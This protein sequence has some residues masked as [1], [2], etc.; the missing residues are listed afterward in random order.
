MLKLITKKVF[1]PCKLR[2]RKGVFLVE[3]SAGTGKTFSISILYLRLL[4]GQC[5]K[6]NLYKNFLE[7]EKILILTFSESD[8]KEFRYRLKKEIR[9]F[10]IACIRGYSS[11]KL[12][13]ELLKQIINIDLVILRLLQ[14]E[15]NM[16][17]SSIFTIYSF[18]WNILK[19][20]PIES[21]ILLK[22][23]LLLDERYLHKKAVVN[24]WRRYFYPLNTNLIKII[25][26]YWKDPNM[27]FID[28]K[29]YLI[30]KLP[31]IC[32]FSNIT[33]SFEERYKLIISFINKFKKQWFK[34]SVNICDIFKYYCFNKMK[35]TEKNFLFWL[36]KIDTWTRTKTI[37]YEIPKELK[38]FRNMI[39]KKNVYIEKI[40]FYKIPFYF[41]FKNL[42]RL[43]HKIFS[44]RELI[45]VLALKEVRNEIKK[46][47][48]IRRQL[49]YND[50]ILKLDC[51]LN[52]KYKKKLVDFIQFHYPVV[53]I[54]GFQDIDLEQYN[55]LYKIYCKN[56]FYGCILFFFSDFKQS[57][58][59]IYT[60]NIFTYMRIRKEICFRYT[61]DINYRSSLNLICAINQ[62]F[63]S[64][65][66][67]FVFKDISFFPLK[68]CVY[69]N[70]F[71]FF[72]N[73]QMQPA[74]H[75]FFKS[76]CAITSDEY[77]KVMS[78]HFSK[79]I[80]D[81][82]ISCIKEE[83]YLTDYFGNRLL[84]LSDIV[85]LVRNSNE[86]KII[87]D[88]LQRFMVPVIFFSNFNNSVFETMEAKDILW[89]L[90]AILTPEDHTIFY[91]A[92]FTDILG[93]STVF[94]RNIRDNKNNKEKLIEK[95]IF[96]RSIWKKRGVSFMLHT[97]L[98]HH[99]MIKNLLSLVD[100]RQRFINVMHIMELLQNVSR[101]FDNQQALIRWLTAQ[102]ANPDSGL[103]N[104]KVR[105]YQYDNN[106]V[107]IMTI[108]KSRGL[109]FPLV[110]LP[111]VAN[112]RLRKYFFF[113]DR[114]TYERKLDFRCVNEKNFCFSDE[115]RLAEDIRLLYVA[116]TRSI[117]YCCIGISPIFHSSLY[118]NYNDVSNV[119][120]SAIGFL[121]QKGKYGDFDFLHKSLMLLEKE[122]NKNIT[123]SYVRLIS[124]K[125]FFGLR[126][127]FLFSVGKKFTFLGENK[128]INVLNKISELNYNKWFIT[129]YSNLIC[130][131]RL[132]V[133][134]NLQKLNLHFCIKNDDKEKSKKL[135][136]SFT[137]PKG[138]LSG[139]FLHDVFE[140][141]DFTC[142][143]NKE[144]LCKKMVRYN[145]D[146]IWLPILIKWIKDIIYYPLDGK[147]LSLS[148]IS[149]DV[150]KSELE[151]YLSVKNIVKSSDFDD[152]CKRYDILSNRR[153]KI[154]FF[155]IHG[156]LN[157]S[158]DLVFFWNNRY[159]LLDYKS[160]WLGN[161]YVDYNTKNMEEAM[162]N[163]K[164][165]LQYQIYSIAL[166]RFLKIKLLNYDY[167]H[168]FGGIYYLFLRGMNRKFMGCGVYY[169]CPNIN[170]IDKLDN[171]F[172]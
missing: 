39:L 122:S 9:C 129:N 145:I 170:L 96:Y 32:Y 90:Q 131:D 19:A 2:L 107:K 62:L 52:S 81:L 21:N 140:C 70:N 161:E 128:N 59:F 51:L 85:I 34:A 73:K 143:L 69:K 109:E 61:L 46:E 91:R 64:F 66:V 33:E 78:Y 4:I 159:Y 17:N 144:W 105:L 147:S 60:S 80:Y 16:S 155:H 165:D 126:K 23:K 162:I 35:Y 20:N 141:L 92:L 121:V 103:K 37:D 125:R 86:A 102:I 123:F 150:K 42:S 43:Y 72:I 168:N 133:K 6:K 22:Q 89:I 67:P 94:I 87:Y 55:I 47:K 65:P 169:C 30:G 142:S 116:I 14:A 135:L 100:G 10:R 25:Q 160:I 127:D 108:Y 27:L 76:G 154:D 115:E 44:F 54:D 36:K 134:N 49:G 88:S 50:L 114:K 5:D 110:F 146:M 12:F 53:I 106:A 166:H 38:Y 93:Y 8:I 74:V 149:S 112:F 15:N 31:I 71:R 124:N 83:S 130:N 79:K 18:F 41:L 29:P 104:Q 68:S 117:Y 111:F 172:C 156:M 57:M 132:H 138:R 119:H 97:M 118:N 98:I 101:N 26:K 75:F 153:P 28:L 56:I 137:F 151:F 63:C 164:F 157:G 45:L 167:I 58:Y 139:I 120:L 13:S 163:H 1:N 158:I 84:K 136:N 82:F 148:S 48:D 95:F 24:F 40:N 171:L 113:H 152:I 11:N 99:G 77:L 7:V 3:A